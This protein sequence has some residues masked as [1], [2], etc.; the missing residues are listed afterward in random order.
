MVADE[1]YALSQ[2]SATATKKIDTILQ[3]I[4]QTVQTTSKIIQYNADIVNTSNENLSNTVTVFQSML[5]SS[6]N[7][8]E[9]ANMLQNGLRDVVAM[10]D[11]LQIEMSQLENISKASVETATSISASTEEQVTGVSAIVASMEQVKLGMNELLE[12]FD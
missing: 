1:I 9:I 6:E 3:D 2:E 10:K 12:L 4:I 5:S 7:V 11:N 8:I